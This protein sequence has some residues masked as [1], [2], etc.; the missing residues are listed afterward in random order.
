MTYELFTQLY[1]LF[2]YA[3]EY[4]NPTVKINDKEFWME[5]GIV[6]SS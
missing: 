5:Q 4:G 3:D 2:G 6:Y 1:D